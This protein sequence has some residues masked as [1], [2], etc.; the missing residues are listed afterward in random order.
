MY[1]K[2]ISDMPIDRCVR[3]LGKDRDSPGVSMLKPLC[4]LRKAQTKLQR[5]S[6]RL[7]TVWKAALPPPTMTTP[8]L[9]EDVA[10][11]S[12]GGRVIFALVVLAGSAVT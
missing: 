7:S 10:A 1:A 3:L 8:A 4:Q 5:T 12:F 9:D 6:R 2:N 11:E